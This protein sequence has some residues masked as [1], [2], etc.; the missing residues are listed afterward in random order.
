MNF[1]LN[2][3]GV[4]SVNMKKKRTPKEKLKMV[5]V[6]IA[7]ILIFGIVIQSVVNF[8]DNERLRDKVE[9]TTVDGLRLDYRI[10]GEGAYTVIFDGD[11]GGDLNEW[12]PIVNELNNN[13]ISTF[14]YNRRGYGN[15]NSGPRRSPEEQASDLKILLRKAG[16][17]GPYI[18]VGEGYGALIATSFV[19]QFKESVS[20]VV[21]VDPISEITIK[22][23]EYKKSQIINRIRRYIEKVGSN[24]GLTMLMDKLSLDINLTDLE[25]R[26]D[27]ESLKEFKAKRTKSG[28]TSAVYNELM[29]LI[30]GESSSQVDGLLNDIPYYLITDNEDDPLKKL[31]G[32]DLTTVYISNC[33][34]DFLSLNDSE[35]ILIGIE[36]VIEDLSKIDEKK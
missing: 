26:L 28:Y 8:I 7:A 24:F 13:G 32:G 33:E 34:K 11:I 22:S 36:K 16:V 9:Y 15:S 18:F 17:S 25:S 27:N 29:N 10:S 1:L 3:N 12:T 31:G 23:S 6:T 30:N 5:A 2:S 19:K 21:L 4:R 14:V 35:N 20:G